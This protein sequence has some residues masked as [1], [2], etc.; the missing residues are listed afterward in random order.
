MSRRSQDRTV[1]RRRK[2]QHDPYTSKIIKPPSKRHLED[3]LK[4]AVRTKDNDVF[5]EYDEYIR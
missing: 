5:E 3:V 4:H 1:P 2:P